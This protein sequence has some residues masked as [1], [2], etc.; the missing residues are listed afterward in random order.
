MTQQLA[1]RIAEELAV[2]LDDLVERGRFATRTEAVRAAIG[3]LIDRE[4]RAAI[5]A[6]IVLGYEKHPETAE[7]LQIADGNLRRL[8]AEEPW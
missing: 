2:G 1:I 3:E 7:E 8:I 4:R 6:A 5:G